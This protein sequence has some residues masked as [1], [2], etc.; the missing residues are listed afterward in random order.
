MVRIQDDLYENVN[1]EW[2]AKTEIPADRPRIGAFDELSINIEK[3]E[4]TDFAEL[5][6][7]NNATGLM[8]EFIKFYRLTSDW[9][10]RNKLGS[11]PA[12]GLLYT[13][14]SID[15]LA[16][17]IDQ[18]I[19][20]EKNWL[21]TGILPLYVDQ[22]MKNTERNIVQLGAIRTIL[23]D[24]SYYAE[25][26]ESEELFELFTKTNVPLL[27]LF[28]Y[29]T[30]QAELLIAEAIKFDK[31]V[32][33]YVLSNE[34]ASDY[35][36]LYNPK[37]FTEFAASIKSINL[38]EIVPALI[39]GVPDIINV[40][41]VRFWEHYDELITEENFIGIKASLILDLVSD[42][43]P[44]LSD[45]IRIAAGAFSRALSGTAEARSNKK[46]ALSL[47]SSV[48]SPIVGDYYGRK[49]FGEAAKAD[50]LDMVKKMIAVFKT[51][52]EANNWLGEETKQKAILKLSTIGLN[53]GYPDT[54][55]ARYTKFVVDEDEDLLS[56]ALRFRSLNAAHHYAQFKVKPDKSEWEMPADMVNAYY[57]PFHN[58]IVF[59][60][61]ILQAPFYSL[62][63]SKSANYGGIGAV[64][65][66]E[67]SHAFDTNGARFDEKGNLNSWWTDAD[68]A[69]FEKR[70]D[71]MVK[72]FDGLENEGAKVNG[73]LV[74]SENVADVGGIS[75]ALEAAKGEAETSL[76]DFFSNW[77]TIWRSKASIEYM[78]LLAK[79]DVH[80]PARLRANV[81][82]TNFED[83]FNTFDVKPG[84]KMWRSPEERVQI[85]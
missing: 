17:L 46:V 34:E 59:P 14:Q 20:L 50:V 29:S 83:F 66:H 49:Y 69:A 65:A 38:K 2:F 37:N 33:Q 40:S 71:A 1:A 79:V 13:Y 11:E 85:W 25:G 63:Q 47:A 9:E 51:R 67:I 80:A 21:P 42:I 60:A 55:P 78:K 6:K 36:K 76:E 32:A 8:G 56:N 12:Q 61:A 15:S 82:V 23:P 28:G 26:G 3:Q 81:Q 5:L 48:F 16:E 7:N 39:D 41:D 18:L 53:V 24:T 70:T 73:K 54:I 64:I 62:N 43:A 44:F 77:A 57:H 35:W 27:E 74:V 4:L 72:E 84:D 10:T 52:L 68:F 75:V 31:K 22:D 58:I 30:E 19:E 45:E